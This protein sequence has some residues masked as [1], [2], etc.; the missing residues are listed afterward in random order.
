MCIGIATSDSPTGPFHDAR[1]ERHHLCQIFSKFRRVTVLR[2]A[3]GSPLQCHSGFSSN[4]PKSFTD[5]GVSYLYW[6]SDKQPISARPLDHSGMEFQVGHTAGVGCCGCAGRP[7]VPHQET[8][9]LD[10]FNRRLVSSGVIA[11]GA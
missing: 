8:R 5:G 1:G 7:S 2:V 6:G 11:V 3:P 9:G 4:D 10:T